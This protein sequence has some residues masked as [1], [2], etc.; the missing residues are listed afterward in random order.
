M[1]DVL[2]DIQNLGYEIILVSFGAIVIGVNK[3]NFHKYPETL[4]IKGLAQL[5]LH[6]KN[7]FKIISKK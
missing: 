6:N 3:L 1:D 2:T 4:K 7:T 5:S